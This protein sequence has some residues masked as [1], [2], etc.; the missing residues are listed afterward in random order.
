M[1]LNEKM[2]LQDIFPHFQHKPMTMDDLMARDPK[3]KPTKSE[4]AEMRKL[5]AISAFNVKDASGQIHLGSRR[6]PNLKSKKK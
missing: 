5:A 4:L 2:K 3:K 1:P 6:D